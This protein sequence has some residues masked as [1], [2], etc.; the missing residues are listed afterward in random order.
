MLKQFRPNDDSINS[1]S[2]LLRV[3][4]LNALKSCFGKDLRSSRLGLRHLDKSIY[5]D[6]MIR[7]LA[8]F[9][10]EQF[11][12]LSLD[13]LGRDAKSAMSGLLQFLEINSS[14]SEVELAILDLHSKRLQNP[15]SLR[16]DMPLK[17]A[18]LLREY[19]SPYD[20]QLNAFLQKHN[21]SVH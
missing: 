18:T 16:P 19:L 12:I 1:S 4:L 7:W 2:V 9:S 21:L 10:S 8:N 11:Y 5:I 6:Q 17:T 20:K 13:S 14:H 15:N 3:S